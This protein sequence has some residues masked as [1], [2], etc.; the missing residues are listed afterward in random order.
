MAWAPDYATAIEL[1]AYVRIDDSVDDAQLALA[2]A[3][4][5][6]AIDRT[7]R[8]QF[9]VVDVPVARFYTARHDAALGRLV[10]DLDDLMSTTGL[11]VEVDTEGDGTYAGT[12]AA[13]D[14]TL[15]PRNAAADGRPWTLLSPSGDSTVGL[16]TVEGAVRI[17]ALWGWSSVPPAVKQACLT[18][19]SRLLARRDAPFGVAGSPEAGSEMRLLAKVDPD[20]AVLLR[21]YTR[22]WWAV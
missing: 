19:A 16:S 2:V 17:T 7:T 11:V 6:R 21:H 15:M 18:Q 20:V 14:Y 4:A 12:I 1:A 22:R 8:R 5:S 13:A 3:A 10:V 9:G